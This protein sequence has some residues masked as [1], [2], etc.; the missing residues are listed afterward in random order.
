MRDG[1]FDSGHTHPLQGINRSEMMLIQS[2]TYRE[3]INTLNKF[4][5]KIKREQ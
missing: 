3:K 1:G 4:K 2:P 5:K